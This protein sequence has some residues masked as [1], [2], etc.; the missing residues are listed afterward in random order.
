MSNLQFY[1][2]NEHQIL[3]GVQM[4][5]NVNA[6][7]YQQR[8]MMPSE[9]HQKAQEFY[10]LALQ[11]FKNCNMAEV[12]DYARKAHEMLESDI[13]ANIPPIPDYQERHLRRIAAL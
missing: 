6:Q 1:Q 3:F 13:K 11:G 10:K 8:E 12:P 5:I 7:W 4:A 2:Q 9:K